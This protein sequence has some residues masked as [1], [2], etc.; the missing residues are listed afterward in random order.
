[1]E[2]ASGLPEDSWCL[3]IH[4]QL[5]SQPFG[6]QTTGQ[7][8]SWNCFS[9][10]NLAATWDHMRKEKGT[11]GI[12]S[13]RDLAD[14]SAAFVWLA[15]LSDVN[16]SK[17][18]FRNNTSGYNTSRNNISRNNTIRST[19]PPR[20]HT[21]AIL[22]DLPPGNRPRRKRKIPCPWCKIQLSVASMV[23]HC[24][25]Y[26]DKHLVYRCQLCPDKPGFCDELGL[27]KH[28]YKKHPTTA[29]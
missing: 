10:A 2:I 20:Q 17:I 18:N 29:Y 14:K 1:V 25:S 28:T 24:R 5:S 8:L 3:Q 6:Q 21:S 12:R 16:H 26:H 27:N 4:R 11:W 19:I 15:I 23:P 22:A 7:Q 9:V 13:H